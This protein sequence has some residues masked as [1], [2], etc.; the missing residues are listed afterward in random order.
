MTKRRIIGGA[1][2]AL[3]VLILSII[4]WHQ[5]RER[6]WQAVLAESEIQDRLSVAEFGRKVDKLQARGIIKNAAAFK[7]ELGAYYNSGRWNGIDSK[8]MILA[9]DSYKRSPVAGLEIY[10]EL[11][12]VFEN[13]AEMTEGISEDFNTFAYQDRERFVKAVAAIESNSFAC[14]PKCFDLSWAEGIPENYQPENDKFLSFLQASPLK[15]N[16]NVKKISA[17]LEYL[18]K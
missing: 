17:Q 6:E 9:H 4:L 11:C 7:S 14:L 2:I 18:K 12:R 15:D 1:A 16:P 13:N 3:V 5:K 10:E 8:V